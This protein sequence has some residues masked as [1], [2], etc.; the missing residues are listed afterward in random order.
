[1][2]AGATAGPA[3]PPIAS[4]PATLITGELTLGTDLGFSEKN[5][6]LYTGRAKL[7]LG[8]RQ[9]KNTFDYDFSYGENAG[10]LAA[11]RMDG[12]VKTDVDL[13]RR[14]Y[15]YSLAG[16]GY[17]E[18]R[19]IKLRYEVGPGVGYHVV[20]ITNFVFNTESGI[21]YQAQRLT[22]DT[23]TDFIFLRLA[24]NLNWQFNAR[25]SWDEKFEFFPEVEDFDVFRFRFETNLRY[26]LFSNLSWNL[27]V[28]DQYDTRPAQAVTRNDLQVRSSVGVKF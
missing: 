5:R 19:K 25:L 10:V 15:I 27:T 13:N 23:S 7:I 18:I 11:N 16:A 6:Q 26:Q 3:S 2:G 4:K 1:V 9:F 17:D 8:H 20:K 24:E 28:I 22:D 12:F 21:D 14:V